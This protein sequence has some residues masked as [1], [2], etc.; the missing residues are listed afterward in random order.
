MVPNCPVASTSATVV[1]FRKATSP[2]STKHLNAPYKLKTVLSSRFQNIKVFLFFIP[3]TL[4]RGHVQYTFDQE[5]CLRTI[6]TDGPNYLP[7]GCKY[8]KESQQHKTGQ[9][10]HWRISRDYYNQRCPY[11]SV[12]SV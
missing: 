12:A 10:T 3:D 8:P 5:L 1:C 4:H 9:K 11:V 2:A 6:D 7:M